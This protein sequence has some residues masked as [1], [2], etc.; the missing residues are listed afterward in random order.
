M[1]R[2]DPESCSPCSV[3][4]AIITWVIVSTQSLVLAVGTA[5]V[6]ADGEHTHGGKPAPDCAMHHHSVSAAHLDGGTHH[7]HAA[8]HS[9]PAHRAAAQ[10]SCRCSNKAPST[11][12][13]HTAIIERS[14]NA[15]PSLQ[16]A[17]LNPVVA[18]A[19]SDRDE[20]PASP[21]HRSA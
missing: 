6:C 21:P 15:T 8:A 9:A 12:L 7:D 4:L 14:F 11:F 18:D 13:G 16:A 2:Q 20:S 3:C 10:L 1:M 5:Q 17:V 19:Y